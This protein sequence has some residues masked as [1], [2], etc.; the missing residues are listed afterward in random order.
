M[1][2]SW[3][4]PNP[5]ICGYIQVYHSPPGM[6]N[7]AAMIND[8]SGGTC[9]MKKCSRRCVISRYPMLLM[10]M[11]GNPQNMLDHT[12]YDDL[13][14]EIIDFLQKRKRILTQNGLNDVIVDVGFGFCKNNEP[15]L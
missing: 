6:E 5:G 7:G 11:K 4:S 1:S 8:I 13:L 2:L 9:W 10:H 3:I 15:K 12:R 14:E